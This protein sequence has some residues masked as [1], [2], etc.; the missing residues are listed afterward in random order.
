MPQ[1]ESDLLSGFAFI[2]VSQ[3]SDVMWD[4]TAILRS[5]LCCRRIK[6]RVNDPYKKKTDR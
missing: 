3:I 4:E 2:S 1:T 6:S 5:N